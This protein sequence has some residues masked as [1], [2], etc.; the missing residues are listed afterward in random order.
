[1]NQFEE[2][3]DSL[4]RHVGDELLRHIAGRLSES[5]RPED[6]LFRTG[7]DEFAVLFAD[8]VD[9]TTV[10][11]Q[12]GYLVETLLAPFDLDQ[13][14]VQV[15]AGVGIALYPDHCADPQ[16]LLNR[17]EAAASHAKAVVSRIAV[18]DAAEE[19]QSGDGPRLVE[20]LREAL[21]SCELTCHYQPK[22]SALGGRVH[23]VEALVRWPHP[24]RGLLLPDQFLPAA[25]KAGLMRPVTARVL[26]LAL[27]Q[28]RSW[29][30]QGIALTVAVNLS[31]TN[32]LD[33]GLVDTIDRLLRTHQLPPDALILEL[34]ES[35]LATDSQRSRNTVTALRRLGIRL[36]LDDYGT[37]WS[38]LARLQDLSVD[39][40][41]LDKVFVARLARDPRSIAI[42]RST[43]ALAHSL[44]AD[45]VAEGVEDLATLQALRRYGCSITQGYVHCPPVP[46]DRLQQWVTNGRRRADTDELALQPSADSQQIAMH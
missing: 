21:S 32:L 24:T 18:Y 34:T 27:A 7:G 20:D 3:N 17:A 19:T 16:Q 22:I 44:G 39:E 13:I 45:L 43:V 29:R 15:D 30:D 42:V 4:G 35:T 9:L 2:I 25:E 37:G 33:V 6:L 23:S 40:L 38:S 26:D 31:T 1:M 14:T 46:A 36:S 5:L 10:R 28:I 8:R 11:A 12:A 41:K